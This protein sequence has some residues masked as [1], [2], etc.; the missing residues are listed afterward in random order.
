MGI[1]KKERKLEEKVLE[2]FGL[3]SQEIEGYFDFYDIK[4]KK[5]RTINSRKKGG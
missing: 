4:P 1:T 2:S 3:L 5:I